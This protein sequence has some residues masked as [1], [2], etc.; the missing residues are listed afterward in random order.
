ME[1]LHQAYR[2]VAQQLCIPGLDGEKADIKKLVQ[3][4]LSREDIGPWLCVFYN[5]DD[6]S[7]W[8]RVSGSEP[9]PGSLKEYLPKS[10][11]GCIV[12]TSRDKKTAVKLAGRNIIEV[13]EMD[14]DG[15]IQLLQKSLI[16]LS[17]LGD[18]QDAK[19]LLKE[20]TYLPLAI[21]QAA[22]YINKNSLT[23]RDYLLL[24][25][26]QE[27][28][29][30]ELLS[31][32]FED[33]WRYQSAKNPVA[34]TWLISFEQIRYRDPLA[35]DYLLFMACID[36]KDIPQSLLPAGALRKNEIEAIGTLRA[37]SFIIKRGEAMVFDLHQLV[38][39][40]TR[41]WLRKEGTLPR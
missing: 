32:E 36:W 29:I 4:H 6:L 21:I 40:A 33:D 10:K 30:I 17:L 15:A 3:A 1:S 13:P 11:Q 37:Y 18:Q 8:I 28:G 7:M 39:L 5:A 41:N 25:N 27:E 22:A 20:L 14:E 12:F 38:H 31:E 9:G 2:N 24:L 23:L 34:T 35:A 19:T 16:D 26:K